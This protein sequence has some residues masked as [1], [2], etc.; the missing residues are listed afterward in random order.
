MCQEHTSSLIIMKRYNS[1]KQNQYLMMENNI[2]D[3]SLS[4]YII[5]PYL[6]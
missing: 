3:I 4:I 5:T 2:L 6:T 1:K